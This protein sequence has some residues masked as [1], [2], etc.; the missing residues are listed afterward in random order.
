MKHYLYIIMWMDACSS[1]FTKEK[2]FQLAERVDVGFLIT[3]DEITYTIASCICQDSTKHTLTIPKSQ[4]KEV[5]STNV[6]VE[7]DDHD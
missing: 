7:V 5:R 4:V 2:T 6:S 1:R 3:E